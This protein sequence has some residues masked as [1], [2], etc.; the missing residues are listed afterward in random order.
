[1]KPSSP[2]NRNESNAPSRRRCSS[3]SGSG[4]NLLL[5]LLCSCL[6]W[7]VWVL[8]RSSANRR[9][10]KG[11][12][13]NESFQYT[14]MHI[15]LSITSIYHS[16][17]AR[18]LNGPCVLAFRPNIL[19]SSDKQYIKFPRITPCFRLERVQLYS[20]DDFRLLRKMYACNGNNGNTTVH[21]YAYCGCELDKR[22]A[23][24]RIKKV[25]YSKQV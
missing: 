22:E 20:T 25:L 1:M 5:S 4:C 21:R 3:S 11:L 7:R 8:G 10:T 15:H 13:L 17:I 6:L 16:S 19:L 9:R 2:R 12:L 24:E 18:F 14:Y 23:E